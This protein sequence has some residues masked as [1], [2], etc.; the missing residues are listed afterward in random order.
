MARDEWRCM[1]PVLDP[2]VAPGECAGRFNASAW[3]RSGT[4]YNVRALTL[5]HVWRSLAEQA[6]GLK[7]PDRPEN[8]ITVCYAHHVDTQRGRQWAT[9]K[10]GKELQRDYLIKLY[11]EV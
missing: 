2:E 9:S 7:P 5:Q 8:L 6:T 3:D 11:P 10:R 1:A 4:R